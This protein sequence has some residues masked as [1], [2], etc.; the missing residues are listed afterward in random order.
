MTLQVGHFGLQMERH[1]IFLK[2]SDQSPGE[3]AEIDVGTGD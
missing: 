2:G 1:T 3:D